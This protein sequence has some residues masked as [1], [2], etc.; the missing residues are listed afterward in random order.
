[1]LALAHSTPPHT[2]SF[3]LLSF[4]F[5]TYAPFICFCA[6]GRGCCCFFRGSLAMRQERVCVMTLFSQIN[7]SNGLFAHD[8]RYSQERTANQRAYTTHKLFL[9]WCILHA[10]QYACHFNGRAKIIII[11]TNRSTESATN[12]LISA[13]A[14][15]LMP[16]RTLHSHRLIYKRVQCK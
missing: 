2:H 10:S 9:N 5:C 12:P 16:L 14:A 6:R 11:I 7:L 8:A 13:L 3:A 1:M 15:S 4:T